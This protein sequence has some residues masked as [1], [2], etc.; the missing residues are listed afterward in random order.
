MLNDGLGAR[1][2]VPTGGS[3][4]GRCHVKG[5]R[6]FTIKAFEEGEPDLCAAVK[7]SNKLAQMFAP[8]GTKT[9]QTGTSM[10]LFF[11]T[12][13]TLLKSLA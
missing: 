7:L 10:T 13:H 1:G 12:T 3:T 8:S 9:R 4:A 11:F 2:C 6:P 5:L